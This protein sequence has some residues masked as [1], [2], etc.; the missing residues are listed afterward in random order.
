MIAR[1]LLTLVFS[2]TLAGASLAQG[3]DLVFEP[4]TN[5]RDELMRE[6]LERRGEFNRLIDHLNEDVAFNES[7]TIVFRPGDKN[8]AF[9]DEDSRTIVVSYGFVWYIAD[10]FVRNGVIQDDWGEE[11]F[12]NLIQPVIDET[13]LHETAHALIHV[14]QLEHSGDKETAA[15]K[16]VVYI[17]NDFYGA[18]ETALPTSLHYRLLSEEAGGPERSDYL[19]QHPPSLERH[20]NFVCW[21]YGSDPEKFAGLL[22]DL[23]VAR[24]PDECVAAFG[25][26]DAEWGSLLAP[27]RG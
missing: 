11:D 14:N 16:L 19:A 7:V 27:S 5:E 22:E 3:L 2:L 4:A 13:I 24:D 6:L 17:I 15:D 1:T 20:D 9:Y 18:A 25:Q 12:D 8:Q 10:V 23:E 21:I 26:L